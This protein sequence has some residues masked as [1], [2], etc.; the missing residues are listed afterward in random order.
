MGDLDASYKNIIRC[1]KKHCYFN[2]KREREILNRLSGHGG[3]WERVEGKFLKF[4][5]LY[6]RLSFLK[7]E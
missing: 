7:K 2:F 1:Q 4:M 5:A 6:G 3:S